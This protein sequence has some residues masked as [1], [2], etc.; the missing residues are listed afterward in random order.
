VCGMSPKTP[1]ESNDWQ[2]MHDMRIFQKPI[3]ANRGIASAT[4]AAKGSP[5]VELRADTEPL[6]TTQGDVGRRGSP[7]YPLNLAGI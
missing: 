2:G 6:P 3:Y 5:Q 7:I 4:N 1:L